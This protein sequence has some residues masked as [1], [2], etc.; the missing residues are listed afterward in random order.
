MKLFI[1]KECVNCSY[2]SDERDQCEMGITSNLPYV[3]AL[4]CLLFEV[5]NCQKSAKTKMNTYCS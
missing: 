4:L 3:A 5:V 1:L 2:C